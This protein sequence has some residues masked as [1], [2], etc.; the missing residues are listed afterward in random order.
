GAVVPEPAKSA[1]PSS[2][3]SDLLLGRVDSEAKSLADD[4]VFSLTLAYTSVKQ[5]VSVKPHLR[6]SS[7]T[8]ND[9]AEGLPPRPEGRGFRPGNTMSKRNIVRN[10]C[11]ASIRSDSAFLRAWYLVPRGLRKSLAPIEVSVLVTAFHSA[12]RRQTEMVR[13]D[14]RDTASRLW[15]ELDSERD[16]NGEF[17]PLAMALQAISDH[18][19][20]CG[21]DEP[22][23]CL[24]CVCEAAL[25]DLWIALKE[26]STR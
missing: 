14:A 23:S 7:I 8:S 11:R 12:T 3:P 22:G 26:H 18:G 10:Q 6:R 13:Q 2:D 19:C 9:S 21:T 1:F 5:A 4:H 25:K 24:A 16:A 15:S 20:D 17:T